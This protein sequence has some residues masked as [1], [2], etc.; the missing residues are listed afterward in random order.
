MPSTSLTMAS[1]KLERPAV[2]IQRVQ[3]TRWSGEFGVQTFFQIS[4]ILTRRLIFLPVDL[5]KCQDV[6][7]NVAAGT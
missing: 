1:S 3:F 7:T 2:A 4:D 6:S 5:D